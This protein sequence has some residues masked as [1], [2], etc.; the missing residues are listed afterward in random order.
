MSI[1]RR[2]ALDELKKSKKIKIKENIEVSK[3]K[4]TF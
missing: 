4:V 2:H 1:F 3:K